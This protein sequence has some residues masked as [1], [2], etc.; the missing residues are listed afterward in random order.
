[1]LAV[2]A[3]TVECHEHDVAVVLEATVHGIGNR[4]ATRMANDVDRV[5]AGRF[6]CGDCQIVLAAVGEG[7]DST[8]GT[9]VRAAWPGKGTELYA[10]LCPLALP[11]HI[12]IS[13]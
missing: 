5:R 10:I 9:G 7:G 2:G 8:V 1:L 13:V 12:F 3:K 4:A 6:D 11:S